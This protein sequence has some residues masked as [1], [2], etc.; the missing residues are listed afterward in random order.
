MATFI[1]LET[2]LGSLELELYT[3]H[4]PRTCKNFTELC[5]KGYYDGT[6]FHR[7]IKDFMVQGGDPTGTGS[8]GSSI[9]GYKLSHTRDSIE[10]I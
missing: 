8:G 5:R 7:I 4:A 2:S 9:Y 1:T 3:Q 6:I 10:L